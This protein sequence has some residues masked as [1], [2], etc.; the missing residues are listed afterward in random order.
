QAAENALRRYAYQEAIGH[1]TRGLA[2]L[3]TLPDTP[4]RTQHECDCQLALA[5]AYAAT[6]GWGALETVHAYTRAGDLCRPGHDPTQRLRVLRGLSG[7][8]TFRGELRQARGVCDTYLR[9]ANA[10]PQPAWLLGGPQH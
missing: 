9:L 10:H 4:E 2:L 6:A 1:L 8:H 5:Q 3:Q 7:V